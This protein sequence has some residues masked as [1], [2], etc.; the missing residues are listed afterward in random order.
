MY[1]IFRAQGRQFRAEPDATLR[2]PS[3]EADPGDR[4]TFDDVL[5]AETDG[6]VR[7]GTPALDG[8]AVQAEVVRHGK[9]DKVIVFKMKRRKGYRRK[10][11]H[12]QP[13][14]EIRIVG[15]EVGRARPKKRKA[16]EPA[17]AA[18]EAPAK[19]PARA[20]EA[21]PSAKAKPEAPAAAAAP[22]PGAAA[23][24]DVTDAARQLAE[25][26]GIDL[27]AIRGSGKE[28]RILK[29]DVEKAIRDRE[30]EA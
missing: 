10:Q 16:A 23:E 20:R 6:Q 14:T 15:I 25:E 29:G 18:E 17:P 22:E 19:E 21:R 3:L 24:V 7:I 2:V 4:V 27:S 30:A 11:G 5:L 12:R 1:A 8:A 26:H 13:F 9:D 28:G